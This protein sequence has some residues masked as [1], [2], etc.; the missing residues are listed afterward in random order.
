MF[1]SLGE[2]RVCRLCR[3]IFFTS[4]GFDIPIKAVR[5]RQLS[6]LL[7]PMLGVGCQGLRGM[8]L[9]VPLTR[10]LSGWT[11]MVLKNREKIYV[12]A[13]DGTGGSDRCFYC[14]V[15][16]FVN[17][18]PTVLIVLTVS[19]SLEAKGVKSNWAQISQTFPLSFSSWFALKCAHNVEKYTS[20]A[21]DSFH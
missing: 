20:H 2:A 17:L 5:R 1:F 13:T 6:R 21:S 14:K 7:G 11:V 10:G 18:A 19:I 12:C 8:Y 16:Q 3:R 9:F 15:E 4:P